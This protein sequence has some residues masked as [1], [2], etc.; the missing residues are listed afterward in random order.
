[1][2]R[3]TF[4]AV[5]AAIVTAFSA[6]AAYARPDTRSMTCAGVQSFVNQRG[7]VVMTTG[8]NTFERLVSSARFCQVAEGPTIARVQSS[9]R[10]NCTVR[11]KC[12]VRDFRPFDSIFD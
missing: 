8:Q 10:R 3:A 7:A 11:W 1:M 4:A 5:I 12:E 9:D 2:Q 6:S